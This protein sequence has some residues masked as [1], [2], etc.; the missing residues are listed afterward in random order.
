VR[1]ERVCIVGGGLTSAHLVLEALAR[2]AAHVTLLCRGAAPQNAP[3]VS[4]YDLETS[5]A[6]FTTACCPV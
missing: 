6:V 5:R 2:G 3:R 1:G 4:Q